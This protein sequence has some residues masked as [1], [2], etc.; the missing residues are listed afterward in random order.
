MAQTLTYSFLDVKA[1]ITGPGGTISLGSGAGSSEE[2]VTV[3]PS[4]NI[5]TMVIGADGSPMHSL[6]A[7]KSGR[8]IV[9]LLKTSP[10]NNLLAAMMEFQRLSSA[11]HGQNTVTIVNIAS[12]DSITCRSVAFAKRP[13]LAYA[14][15]A[16]FNDWEFNCGIIDMLLGAGVN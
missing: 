3:E 8:V 7:D 9:R 16:G 5:D 11:T 15:E 1:A 2:G 12:G 10:T 6:L 4:E 14:K 13:N